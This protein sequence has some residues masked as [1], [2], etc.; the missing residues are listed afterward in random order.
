L[1]FFPFFLQSGSSLIAAGIFIADQGNTTRLPPA[2][3]SRP[4]HSAISSPRP[5]MKKQGNL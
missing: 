4:G 2:F 3:F 1:T 5:S